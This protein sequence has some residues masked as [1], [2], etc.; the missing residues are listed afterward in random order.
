MEASR[1]AIL[2]GNPWQTCQ[3]YL[4]Q[5]AQSYVPK[6]SLRTEVADY[7]RS[8]FDVQNI[9]TAESHLKESVEK[10]ARIAPKLADWMEVNLPEGF[11]EFAFPRLHQKRLRTSNLLERLSQEI[12]RRTKVIRVFPNENACLRLVS[13]VLMKFSKDWEFGRIYLNMEIT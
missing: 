12:K 6:V 5:N 9:D 3:F 13:A 11:S 7:I 2:G 1:K 4:K 8:F 10:Y